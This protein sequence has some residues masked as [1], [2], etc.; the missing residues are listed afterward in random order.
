MYDLMFI[1]KA[2]MNVVNEKEL[3]ANGSD[4]FRFL[5]QCLTECMEQ[6]LIRFDDLMTA[7]LS[8]W[9]MGHGL[10][11]LDI[12]CRFKVMQMDQDDI[13][14]AIKKAIAEYLQLIKV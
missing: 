8:V 5:V 6:K 11:S 4:T 13:N 12:R 9:A 1:I 2:P 3:W 14:N 10:V 7:A